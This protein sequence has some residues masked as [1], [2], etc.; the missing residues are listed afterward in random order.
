MN[1]E[2]DQTHQGQESSQVDRQNPASGSTD[3]KRDPFDLDQ[4][5]L[6][7]NFTDMVGV[8]RALVTVPVKKPDRQ[9]FIRVHP[10]E[11]YRL[12]TAIL[13]QREDREIYLVD[14]TLWPELPGEIT[15]TVLHT[16]VPPYNVPSPTV[17]IWDVERGPY[18]EETVH[19]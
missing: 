18:G 2:S 6:S 1:E 5:R 3:E 7:Q 16:D 17:R 19:S 15:P 9:S 8:K 11:E 13:N 12:P 10:E 14:H 4:L